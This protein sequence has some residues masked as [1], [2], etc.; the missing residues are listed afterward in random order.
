MGWSGK[1]VGDIIDEE[2]VIEDVLE[3]S[4]GEELVGGDPTIQSC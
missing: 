4:V 3:E 2:L 1:E